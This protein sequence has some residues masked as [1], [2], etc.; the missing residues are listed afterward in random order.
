MVKLQ[1]TKTGGYT[2]SLP[3]VKC[4]RKGWKGGE[5]FDVE[6]DH[7]GNLVLVPITKA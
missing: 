6:F 4:E 1:R 3:K 5:E 2:I 7:Q